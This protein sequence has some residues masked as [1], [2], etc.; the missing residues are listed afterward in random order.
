MNAMVFKEKGKGSET[1][2]VCISRD[3]FFNILSVVLS[4]R[5]SVN[6]GS[7]GIFSIPNEFI[8]DPK[9][10][11]Y[12]FTPMGDSKKPEFSGLLLARNNSEYIPVVYSDLFKGGHMYLTYKKD[13]ET[14]S[15]KISHYVAF[16]FGNCFAIFCVCGGDIYFICLNSYR[17]TAILMSEHDNGKIIENANIRASYVDLT[18]EEKTE[19]LSY[20]NNKGVDARLYK[21]KPSKE[22]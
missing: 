19:L 7:L 13:N 16:V 14:I 11:L 17:V 20:I 10:I 12:A 21:N 9:L 1:P 3:I 2:S 15:E 22:N 5:K 6:E 18:I 8:V 4:T